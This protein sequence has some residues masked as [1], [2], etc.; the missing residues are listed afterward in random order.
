[1]IALVALTADEAEG[2]LQEWGEPRHVDPDP[3]P[4]PDTLDLRLQPG[5]A[6]E[7]EVQAT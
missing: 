5:E 7:H 3:S 6:L 2:L 4:E 1:M